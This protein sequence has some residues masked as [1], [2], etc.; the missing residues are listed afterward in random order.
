[1]QTRRL[2][3]LL[4]FAAFG[5]AAQEQTS[6]PQVLAAVADAQQALT[7]QVLAA[8]VSQ[9]FTVQKLID[10]VGGM[11]ELSRTLH[12]AQQIGGPR[13]LDGQTVQVRLLIEGA[14]VAQTLNRIVSQN[15][16]KSPLAPQFVQRSLA[17]WHNR[18]FSAIG[19]STVSTDVT[20]LQPPA[21]DDNWATVSDAD[22]QKALAMARDNAV[23][24]VLDSLRPIDLG[25]SK[26]LGDALAIP[27]VNQALVTW[28]NS[29]PVASV[30]FR[31]DLS[32]QLALA[33][34][35]DEL[36]QTLKASLT[37]QKQIPPPAS[38]AGWDW[39][40]KQVEARV[41]SPI[42]IGLAQP[43]TRATPIEMPAEAPPWANQQL[44]AEAT[45]PTHG[46]KLHTARAAETMALEQLRHQ[47][48]GLA[49]TS[50]MTVG[51]AASR[52][53]RIEQ[54]VLRALNR[55]HPYQVDYKAQGAVTVHVSLSAAD[56][57]GQLASL[58]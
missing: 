58:R 25:S 10:S 28:L 1:M 36:W 9:D 22:R 6:N 8:R 30:E 38:R 27:Q 13:W 52:D 23:A 29:R 43:A 35:S 57:W 34:S 48:E 18:T 50:T 24:R 19:T 55:A 17:S 4:I 32:V 41:A 39:L 21:H 54:A 12:A 42:G 11:D 40:A 7:A 49:L 53:P 46:S 45:S 26:T 51:E 37:Q 31:Q 15:A 14:A 44:Q 5:A 47:V 16:G 3:I 20:R 56:L 33:M 2:I